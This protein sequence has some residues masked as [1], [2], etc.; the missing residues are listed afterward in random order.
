MRK[1]GDLVL[2]YYMGKPTVY[3]R[4]ENIEPDVKEGWYQVDL[5]ILSIPAQRVKWILREEYIDGATFTMGGIPLRLG[6]I[7]I[8]TSDDTLVKEKENKDKT[9]FQKRGSS[10]SKVINLKDFKK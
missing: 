1:V 3:A 7:E 8:S 9:S 4:I 6:E 10:T 2:I 5:L